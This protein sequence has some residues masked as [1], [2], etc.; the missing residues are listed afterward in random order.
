MLTGALCWAGRTC[1]DVVRVCHGGHGLSRRVGG[2]LGAVG[3]GRDGGNEG[4]CRV[5]HCGVEAGRGAGLLFWVLLPQATGEGES[6]GEGESD[7][8]DESSN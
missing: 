1:R 8:R 3:H 7:E 5:E 6:E 2:G 4:C